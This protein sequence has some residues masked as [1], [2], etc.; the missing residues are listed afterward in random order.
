MAVDL[1]TLLSLR[2]ATRDAYITERLRTEFVEG[3]SVADNRQI[4]EGSIPLTIDILLKDEIREKLVKRRQDREAVDMDNFTTLANIDRWIAITVPKIASLIGDADGDL[5][6]YDKIIP[7]ETGQ[8]DPY[9]TRKLQEIHPFLHNP[10]VIKTGGD[11]NN[12]LINAFLLDVSETF[13]NLT[14]LQQIVIASL[15]RI[16]VIYALVD[17]STNA[18]KPAFLQEILQPVPLRNDTFNFLCDHFG[19]ECILFSKPTANALPIN[20]FPAATVSRSIPFTPDSNVFGVSHNGGHYSAVKFDAG[21]TL[22]GGDAA[23]E[24]Y[25]EVVGDRLAVQPPID[26]PELDASMKDDILADV[27]ENLNT[28]NAEVD[29]TQ[30][31]V[32]TMPDDSAEEGFKR[33]L[34]LHGLNLALQA[35]L[36]SVIVKL[37]INDLSSLDKDLA[38]IET[39]RQQIDAE[40]N[41]FDVIHLE[42]AALAASILLLSAARAST[43]S[44]V[45]GLTGQGQTGLTGQGQTVQTDQGQTGLPTGL[46]P[47]PTGPKPTGPK[48]TGQT[49]QGPTGQ[50]DQGQTGLPTGLPP[51]PSGP[52]PTG[53]TDQGLPTGLPPKPSG[54]KPTGSTD[55]GLPTGL[56]PKPS[57]PKPTGQTDQLGQTGQLGPTVPP[58]PSGPK[59]TGQTDQGPTGLP[60]KPSGPK[61]SGSIFGK[62]NFGWGK[63]TP[64]PVPANVSNAPSNPSK[65]TKPTNSSL[66]PAVSTT[67]ASLMG[68]IPH[69]DKSEE[70]EIKYVSTFVVWGDKILAFVVK[71]KVV[72]SVDAETNGM[73][74]KK[75]ARESL[76]KLVQP[77]LE[78]KNLS[79]FY[80]HNDRVFI[81]AKYATKPTVTGTGEDFDWAEIEGEAA[82]PTYYWANII[83][84][85]HWL[86]TEKGKADADKGLS[87]YLGIL[88]KIIGITITNVYTEG[89]MPIWAI[90]LFNENDISAPCKET[91]LITSDC[92]A[93]SVRKHIIMADEYAQEGRLVKRLDDPELLKFKKL[94]EDA[95]TETDPAKRRNMLMEINDYYGD[96]EVLIGDQVTRD[97]HSYKVPNPYRALS[98]REDEVTSFGQPAGSSKHDVGG[99]MGA[100]NYE[101]AKRLIPKS[102]IADKAMTIAILESL[103]FC[104]Q[105]PSISSDPRCFPARLLEELREYQR[106]KALVQTVKTQS[107]IKSPPLDNHGWPAVQLMVQT[108]LNAIAGAKT[109]TFESRLFPFKDVPPATPATETPATET[110][111]TETPATETPATVTPA[112]VTPATVTPAT[113]TPATVT[114]VIPTPAT[115]IPATVLTKNLE[116]AIVPTQLGGYGIRPVLPG[117]ALGSIPV[118]VRR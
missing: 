45:T 47:K 16:D 58:K 43:E 70:Q 11:Q 81:F 39:A 72:A 25:T 26:G 104:G 87:N 116:A 82:S 22:I 10:V 61:P 55:Q 97:V 108:M 79:I 34:D 65:P 64:K 60:P 94:V 18:G 50:T 114:P 62:W 46:P 37:E 9:L 112:T 90:A 86:V 53:S 88:G 113:V 57:G 105:N 54:P 110:P 14:Y 63:K 44:M 32:E 51:K 5:S 101:L 41:K 30:K 4:I 35:K 83:S 100:Q 107:R 36:N 95:A 40:K 96:R 67:L 66:P 91:E 24:I 75:V 118:F 42:S 15:F 1:E 71:G 19:L 103:W 99:I 111:A 78:E 73:D 29:A 98:Y 106:N 59:P 27:Q 69:E 28:I 102:I 74:P 48:P 7:R 77:S 68:A 80:K 52:K 17:R 33:A 85:R 38:D 84:L 93:K 13:R 3:L 21:S 8:I 2:D 56:P 6:R 92:T 31:I 109:P 12:C 23:N 89:Q 115:V 76:I 117:R 49:D 20:T